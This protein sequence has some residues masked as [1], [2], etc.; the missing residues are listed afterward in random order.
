[1]ENE[2]IYHVFLDCHFSRFLWRAIHI[3]FGSYP[4]H[5]YVIYTFRDWL[6]GIDKKTKKLILVE[7]SAICWAL[8]LGRN[9]MVL[10]KAPSKS[11]M[12]VLFRATYWLWYW[13]QLQRCDEDINL[14]NDA[15]RKLE[16]QSCRFSPI[17]DEDSQIEFNN[18]R[19]LI[20]CWCLYCVAL[21]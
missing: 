6:V 11:Y 4:R 18:S 14:T 2:T 5:V 3:A 15:C 8:W 13:A 17:S 1:M 16:T 19:S 9:D 10:I 20:L 21:C 12:Q 7:A